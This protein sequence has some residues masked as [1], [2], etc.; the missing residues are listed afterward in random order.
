VVEVWSGTTNATRTDSPLHTVRLERGFLHRSLP[1]LILVTNSLTSTP[2]SW[3]GNLNDTTWK[4]SGAVHD[5]DNTVECRRDGNGK[6]CLQSS[7][8][9]AEP[10]CE[11]VLTICQQSEQDG[12]PSPLDPCSAICSWN[13]GEAVDQCQATDQRE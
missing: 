13:G 7:R 2:T 1:P 12:Q 3:S 4:S 6:V 8:S 10:E 9:E 11:S 5:L